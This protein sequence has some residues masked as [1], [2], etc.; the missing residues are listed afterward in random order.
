MQ[1]LHNK[2]APLI[3]LLF[4]YVCMY[5]NNIYT[6][7][8]STEILTLVVFVVRMLGKVIEYTNDVLSTNGKRAGLAEMN[9]RFSYS[10]VS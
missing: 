5:I 2:H 3:I 4:M 9:A 8:S 7:K 10:F 6:I 1:D